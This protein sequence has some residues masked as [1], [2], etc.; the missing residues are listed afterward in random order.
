MDGKSDFQWEEFFREK[1][2]LQWKGSSILGHEH[3]KKWALQRIVST[4][5]HYEKLYEFCTCYS[6]IIFA[7]KE[8]TLSNLLFI[9]V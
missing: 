6:K 1:A 5:V 3:L 2:H 4:Q 7:L 8:F 9:R